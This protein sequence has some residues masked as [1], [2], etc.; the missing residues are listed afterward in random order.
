MGQVYVRFMSRDVSSSILSFATDLPSKSSSKPFWSFEKLKK[1]IEYVKKEY[2]P[3]LTERS[4]LILTRYYQLQRQADLRNSARTTI[5]LLESLVRI[6][7]AHAKLMCHKEVEVNDAVVA[8]ILIECSFQS[9][10]VCGLK[11]DVFE[12]FPNDS[13]SEFIS[14]RNIFIICCVGEQILLKLGL[15]SLNCE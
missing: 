11:S 7:Q 12:S 13:D 4:S 8:I 9:Q 2:A 6:S 15:N 1:Y 5:R 3:I 14:Q 10:S